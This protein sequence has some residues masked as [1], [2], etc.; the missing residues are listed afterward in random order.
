M[1]N[2]VSK[3]DIKAT[4]KHLQY[5][6]Y[7]RQDLVNYLGHFE[8]SWWSCLKALFFF[9]F[10]LSILDLNCRFHFGFELQNYFSMVNWIAESR[11]SPSVYFYM[12]LRMFIFAGEG[13]SIHWAL[14][15]LKVVSVFFDNNCC[16]FLC[17][18]S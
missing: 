3:Q 4:F 5:I 8:C 7:D 10:L 1:R 2:K 11:K 9:L 13:P 18:G 17:F 15:W 16:F 14:L 12:L 6:D